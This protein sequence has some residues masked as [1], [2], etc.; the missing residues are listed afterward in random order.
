[1]LKPG[2]RNCVP[3]FFASAICSP[4]QR[5]QFARTFARFGGKDC[6]L[7]GVSNAAA[8]STSALGFGHG[9]LGGDEQVGGPGDSESASAS[10]ANR[11]RDGW[12]RAVLALFG[13]GLAQ[14]LT[15]LQGFVLVG[16]GCEDGKGV[17][18]GPCDNIGAAKCRAQDVG[19]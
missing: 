11:D 6:E 17:A 16:I 18:A 3:G 15:K 14:T 4:T 13:Q 5:A 1:M 12:P 19:D 7:C 8:V 2:T 10:N 9:A